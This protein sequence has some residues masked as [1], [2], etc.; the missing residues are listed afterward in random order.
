MKTCPV[1]QRWLELEPGRATVEDAWYCPQHGHINTRL[2]ERLWIGKQ[3]D[4]HARRNVF[5]GEY[6]P[7]SWMKE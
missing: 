2:S 6:P 7:K 5:M 3:L 4:E 1:C